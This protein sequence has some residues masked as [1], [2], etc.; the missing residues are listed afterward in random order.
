MPADPPPSIESDHVGYDPTTGTYHAAF[1]VDRG[2]DAVVVAVVETIGA[3]TGRELT[4][5]PPLY[6]TVN[7]SALGDLISAPREKPI[8]VTFT[9]DGVDVRVSSQGTVV[10]RP[11]DD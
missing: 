3:I 1:G 11:V 7:P 6:R 5:I 10:A 8:N 4:E 2:S 9:H